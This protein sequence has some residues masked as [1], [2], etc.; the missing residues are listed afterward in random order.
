[1]I[2]DFPYYGSLPK[3]VKI[4]FISLPREEKF[5]GLGA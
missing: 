5:R 4:Q 1:M 2:T 3:I